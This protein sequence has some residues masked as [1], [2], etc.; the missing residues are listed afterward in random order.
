MAVRP[1]L[2]HFTQIFA[3]P[4][5][6]ADEYLTRVSG[7]ELKVLLY[8]FRYPERGSDL[9]GLATAL[10]LSETELLQ[11]LSFWIKE[12]FLQSDGELP[13]LV[14][15]Q[16]VTGQQIA[17]KLEENDTLRELK[18]LAEQCYG[19]PLSTAEQQSVVAMYQNRRLP[20]DVILMLIAYCVE[21]GKTGAKYLDTVAAAWADEGIVTL[22]LAE[23]RLHRMQQQKQITGQVRTAFGLGSRKLTKKEETYIK[24]WTEQYGYGMDMI[25]AAYERTVDAIS[26]CSF[27]YI[28]TILSAWH[29]KQFKTPED[30]AGD[31]KPANS[32]IRREPSYQTDKL[33]QLGLQ[34]PAVRKQGNDG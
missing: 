9:P 21:E 16:S 34:V 31:T 29:D 15:P 12:G 1:N 11:I 28:N 17:Q 4:A 22:E 20:V 32:R 3:V 5:N 7:E 8:L 23:E 10:S 19:R 13:E 30:I 2:Q 14:R 33:D 18:D 6:L 24:T 25:M 26:N 27:P